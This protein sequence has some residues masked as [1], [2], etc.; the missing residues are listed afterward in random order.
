MTRLFPAWFRMRASGR[1]QRPVLLLG[2]SLLLFGVG[3]RAADPAP[4][5]ALR[6]AYFDY[7]QQLA[8]RAPA[9]LPV[10]VVD[11]DEAS[12]AEIGQFPWPRTEFVRLL[13]RLEALG[14]AVVAFDILFAEPDRFSP[15]A[16]A[17]DPVMAEALGDAADLSPYDNDIRFAEAMAGRP[18]VLG[19]AARRADGRAADLPPK[20]GL[21][22]IG[23]QPGLGL[24]RVPAT[25]PLAP[26]L[27]D[28]AAGIG[29]INVAPGTES[30][31]VRQ[32]PL[33]WQAP[34]GPLPALALE[35]LRLALGETTYFLDGVPDIPGAVQSVGIG[36][37]QVP[38][39]TSGQIWVRY[40]H[41]DPSLYVPAVDILR[42]GDD[43]AVRAAVEGQIVFVGTSAA[44]LLD[45][46]T[47]ALGETVPGVSI[48]AQIVE[49]ILLGEALRRSDFVAGLEL[50]T[51]VALGLVVTLLMARSGASLTLVSGGLAAAL[52]LGGSWLAFRSQGVLFDATFPLLGGAANFATLVGYRFLVVDRDKRRIRRSFAQYVAPEV[53]G[54]IETS[55]HAL[56]LGGVD[57]EVTVLFSDIRN[58]TPL[59]ESLPAQDLV[60]ILN[61]LFTL[62][63][64]EILK[65]KGTID[66][67]IGDAMMA[68]WN[69]PLNV[70]DH[71]LQAARAALGM[72]A[73]LAE[74]NAR[75]A[76][77][78]AAPIGMAVGCATGMACVGNIGS[79]ERFNYTVIGDA[80][81]AAARIEQSCRRLDYDIVVSGA[82]ARTIAGRLATLE[83]G[84]PALKGV[85]ERQD[86]YLVVG[87]RDLAESLA[88]AKLRDCHATLLEDLRQ[89]VP[90]DPETIARCIER[91]EAVEPGLRAFYSAIPDRTADFTE[92][93]PSR[94]PSGEAQRLEAH[95]GATHS[96]ALI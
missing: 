63:G 33:L 25:T 24:I 81:N 45:T 88:F 74:F 29:G 12:L 82:V 47:T 34:S 60:A 75:R 8:P 69:A 66:K 15:A 10:R 7:L 79:R 61:D 68:F 35:A 89:G 51:F 44:G 50:L 80:V 83:A 31:I 30:G 28:A 52:V 19:V 57:R 38:T 56:N 21:V 72:R 5:R 46:R 86:L 18:V 40:R 96:S 53:L 55:G 59:S 54:E 65:T 76:R 42:G 2:L 37:Y 95:T 23:D 39:D 85:S 32:V 48:H 9:D 3:L 6:L 64:A 26:P 36:P 67:F 58:F 13:D 14:A 92:T 70:P 84:A 11:I 41:D 22:E 16:L 91:A 1:W 94:P 17:R 77:D 27:G 90:V 49:Q 73:R 93:G 62:H 87:D 78:G 43:P 71:P 20:S 4:L